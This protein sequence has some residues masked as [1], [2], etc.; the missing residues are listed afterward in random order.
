M[1]VHGVVK[2]CVF[3]VKSCQLFLHGTSRSGNARRLG[4]A[5]I[6]VYFNWNDEDELI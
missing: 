1:T 4:K 2:L 6:I 3:K 5:Y